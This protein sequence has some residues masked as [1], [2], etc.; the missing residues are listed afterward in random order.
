MKITVVPILD[1]EGIVIP[2]QL[3]PDE[4]NV[5]VSDP[6]C[7][8]VRNGHRVHPLLTFKWSEMQLKMMSQQKLV[9]NE[10]DP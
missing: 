6:G 2:F 9:V 10:E 1:N 5:F 4:G 7:V 8:D 3:V